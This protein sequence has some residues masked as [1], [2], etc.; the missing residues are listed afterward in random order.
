MNLRAID[1][2]LQHGQ[3]TAKLIPKTL[4][5][6]DEAENALNLRM[7]VYLDGIWIFKVDEDEKRNQFEVPDVLAEDM[8]DMCL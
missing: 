4:N 7:S 3:L 2:T 1:V 8:E 5:L 6:K